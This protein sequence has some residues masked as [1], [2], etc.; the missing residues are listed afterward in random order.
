MM[1]SSASRPSS[2]SGQRPIACRSCS[3]A[4]SVAR[5]LRL[6]PR[7]LLT[8]AGSKKTDLDSWLRDEFFKTHCQ[9]FKNRPFIWHVWDGRKDGFSALVNYHRLDRPAL[10]RLAYTYLGDWI[11][12]QAAGAREDVIGC[13]GA[14]DRGARASAQASADPDRRAAVRHLRSLEAARRA[15]DRLGARSRRWGAA[16][17]AAVRGGRRAAGEV[18]R[19]VGEGSRQEPRR[20]RTPQQ[21]CISPTPR[22]RPLATRTQAHDRDGAGLARGRA[23]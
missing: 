2:A 6:A 21:T 19:Q 9:I 10:E 8:A 16:Q 22:S 7:E 3:P 12:R 13:G 14:L 23:R 20:V 15:G 17:R 18:Q 4:P 5:G 1:A 11:E